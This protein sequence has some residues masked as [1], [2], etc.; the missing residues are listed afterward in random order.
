MERERV[1]KWDLFLSDSIQL[2][3]LDKEA[4]ENKVSGQLHITA[5]SNDVGFNHRLTHMPTQKHIE[6]TPCR[7]QL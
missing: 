3:Y 5:P 6:L 2:K 1:F 4:I 7:H